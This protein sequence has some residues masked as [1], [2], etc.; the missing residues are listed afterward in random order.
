MSKIRKGL[1]ALTA[2]AGLGV[3]ALIATPANAVTSSGGCNDGGGI[4]YTA[5]VDWNYRYESTNDVIRASVSNLDIRRADTEIRADDAG[6]DVRIKVYSTNTL[7]QHKFFDGYDSAANDN[8]TVTTADDFH[9]AVFNPANPVSN[10]DDPASATD[11]YS[12]VVLTIG[13]DSD[14]LGD[15]SI[16]FRQPAGLPFNPAV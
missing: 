13:T 2:V 11:T 12:K 1:A 3:S 9:Q 4:R 5:S 14:G 7:I 6:F 16:T 8:D 15:C 10:G